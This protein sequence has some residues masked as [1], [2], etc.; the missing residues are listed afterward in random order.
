[1]EV[2]NLDGMLL[3]YRA[4][5]LRQ[6]FGEIDDMIHTRAM[7]YEEFSKSLIEQHSQ[8]RYNKNIIKLEGERDGQK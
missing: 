1:M 6:L 2:F 5:L 4:Y 7:S 3:K 8:L